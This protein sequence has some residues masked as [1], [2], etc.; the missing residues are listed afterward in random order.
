MAD[1]KTEQ[2]PSIEE[3]LESIR[4]IISEDGEEAPAPMTSAQPSADASKKQDNAVPLDLTPAAEA[5]SNDVPLDLTPADAASSISSANPDLSAT[6][7]PAE[8][9]S[10]DILELTEKVAAP[11]SAAVPLD[12]TSPTAMDPPMTAND[13]RPENTNAIISE[14][15][16]SAATEALAKLL[17]GSMPIERKEGAHVTL[18]DIARDMI[19]PLLKAWIDQNLPGLV[20]K[21]VQREVE[22]LSRRASDN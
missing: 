17:A 2:E 6:S 18:E 3:I 21:I 16:A 15:A 12:L 5:L 9:A 7:V 13:I 4:Q 8:Q 20:E 11:P 14:P 19:K 10:D 22:K 1:P